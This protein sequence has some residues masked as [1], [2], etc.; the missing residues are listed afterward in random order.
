MTD[1]L[2]CYLHLHGQRIAEGFDERALG[3]RHPEKSDE[4]MRNGSQGS[5]HENLKNDEMIERRNKG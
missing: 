5:Q 1:S 4:H 3:D 2:W